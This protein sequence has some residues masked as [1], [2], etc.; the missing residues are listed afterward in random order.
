V[1]SP[2][3]VICRKTSLFCSGVDRRAEQIE[4]QV[5]KEAREKDALDLNNYGKVLP[6]WYLVLS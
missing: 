5:E 2:S 4:E 1:L 3:E 6:A